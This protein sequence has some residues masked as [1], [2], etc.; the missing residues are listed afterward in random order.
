MT[1]KGGNFGAPADQA[2]AVVPSDATTFGFQVRALYVGTAGNVTVTMSGPEK[3]L[4]TFSNVPSGAILPL[5]VDKVMAATTA[6]NIVA[7]G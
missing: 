7:I 4:V 1:A 2:V 6:A 3:A 5:L